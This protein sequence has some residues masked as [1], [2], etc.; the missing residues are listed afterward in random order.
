MED[1][2]IDNPITQVHSEKCPVCNGFGT[3]K[4]GRI[5]CHA[6]KGKGYIVIPNKIERENH[7]EPTY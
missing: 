7:E 4:Y 2:Q 1:R 3:L 6:C 5:L